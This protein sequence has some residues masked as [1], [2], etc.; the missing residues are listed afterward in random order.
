MEEKK[1]KTIL[2]QYDL[3]LDSIIKTIRKDNAKKVLLQFPDGL[4]P[5]SLAIVDYLKNEVDA[6]LFIWFSTCF[7]A[8]DIPAVSEKDFDL[9]VQFGHS[10][11]NYSL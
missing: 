10:A 4:K 6:D 3:D 7:G 8:C 9:I 1:L 11:W 5:Y 2:E